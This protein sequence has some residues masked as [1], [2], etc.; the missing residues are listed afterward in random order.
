MIRELKDIE[1]NDVMDI[2]LE[3]TITAH[4]FIPEDYWIKNYEV[5]KEE[6][7]PVSKTFVYE[8]DGVIRAFI[9]VIDDA[10][11][12]ALFV[13]EAYQRR[14]I[15]KKLL[16]HCKSLY[17]KLE[18]RVYLKNTSAV[19]FYRKNGFIIRKGQLNE[20]SGFMEYIMSWTKEE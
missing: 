16:D 10:F 8:E 5:V 17:P 4:E 7:I 6:Y 19:G 15:G 14:G 12:G 11:I 18:L 9:S 20:D 1:V 13:S 2:W 3:T